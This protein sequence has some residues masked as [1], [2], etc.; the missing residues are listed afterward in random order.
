MGDL[1]SGSYK[2]KIQNKKH[3]VYK[4]TNN[5]T[6]EYYIGKHSGTE[7]DGYI[8][9]GKLFKIKYFKDPENWE[10]QILHYA[11]SSNGALYAEKNYLGE[12][13]KSDPLCLNLIAGG[14]GSEA[15]LNST[16]AKE[17]MSNKLGQKITVTDWINTIRLDEFVYFGYNMLGRFKV[18]D[19]TPEEFK[20]FCEFTKKYDNKFPMKFFFDGFEF[21][22]C[23]WTFSNKTSINEFIQ[24]EQEYEEYKSCIEYVK[25]IVTD[26]GKQN[27][28]KERQ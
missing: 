21:D 23:N 13:Y 28:K 1:I 17:L 12:L 20:L 25:T 8:G 19:T 5:T 24:S 7:D 4:W 16:K 14:S 3:F 15:R 18:F 22:I 2:S 9:S 11:S 6:G 27:D 10:R 26:Y